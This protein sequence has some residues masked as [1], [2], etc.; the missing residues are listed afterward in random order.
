MLYAL[1]LPGN[2]TQTYHGSQSTYDAPTRLRLRTAA[3]K[4]FANGSLV[5][6]GIR[7]RSEAIFAPWRAASRHIMGL[8]VRG[9]D[10]VIAKKVPPEAYFP[11]VGCPPRACTSMSMAA[12]P[13]G[14]AA[15]PQPPDGCE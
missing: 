5:R 4:L 6:Q 14:R 3:H 9:T 13:H 7:E 12:C 2:F 1:A 11:C 10:K 15:S 8:H